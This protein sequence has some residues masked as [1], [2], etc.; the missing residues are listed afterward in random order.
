MKVEFQ[1][2]MNAEEKALKNLHKVELEVGKADDATMLKYALKAYIVEIQGQ[3]RNN[4]D[5][6]IAGDYPKE[7][8]VG[9]AMFAKR[10][11]EDYKTTLMNKPM[12]QRLKVLLDE[13]MIDVDMYG[14]SIEK[15]F[16]RGEISEDEMT[17]ALDI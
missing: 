7:L 15:L 11:K 1:V 3:I 16:D 8:T 13:G 17:E 12:V 9:Q 5:K 4:W 14:A 10:A 2:A 6:F